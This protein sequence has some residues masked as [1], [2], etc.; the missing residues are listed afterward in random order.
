[1][2]SAEAFVPKVAVANMFEIQSS[3]LA[4]EQAENADVKDFAQRMVD[5]HTK[6]GE[7]FQAAL[8]ASGLG[9][10]PPDAL[11]EEHQQKIDELQAASGADFDR[12]YVDMQVAAH[13]EAVNLF[14]GYA[15]GG[16]NEDLKTFAE[17]T[18]PTLQEH[19]EMIRQI[20]EGDMVAEGEAPADT[21]AEEE[22]AAGADTAEQPADQTADASSDMTAAPA[23]GG[24]LSFNAD[25]VRAST[26][27]G[28][29]VFSPEEESIG[30]VSDLVLQEDGETRAALIDV[31]GFLGVGEKEVAIPF[32]EIEISQPAEDGGEPRLTIAMTKE[33][34]EALPAFE[35]PTMGEETAATEGMATS[36]E[37]AADMSAEQPAT[38]EEQT[39]TTEQ[40]AAEEE[41]PATAEQ[42]TATAEQPATGEE[43]VTEQP[44]ETAQGLTAEE[45]IGTAV[46]GSDDQSL[47]EINDVVFEQGG[48]IEAVVIDVGGFLGIGEKPVAIEFDALNVQKNE[49]GD[50][51]L[52][53]NATQEQL[54]A[55]PTYEEAPAQ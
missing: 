18:L 39:A 3:E 31:G 51:N 4:L 33:E 52:V 1:M 22:M 8:E 43:A 50:V 7:D 25:Q 20:S 49:N 45:L 29:E 23:E 26:L 54:E 24:F 32:N 13:D 37:P 9:I 40:P 6:A 11:D 53:V 46:Y 12:M 14:S 28:K 2:T 19:Q 30:E 55:A 42:E 15:E 35:R 17:N 36:E 16:D 47:G 5:D 41:Q 21:T 44:I 48:Q 27:M 38:T 34:L 10:T